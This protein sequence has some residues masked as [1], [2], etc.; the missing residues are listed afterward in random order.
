MFGQIPSNGSSDKLQIGSYADTY[1][2]GIHTK[3]VPPPPSLY[4]ETQESFQIICQRTQFLHI[5]WQGKTSLPQNSNKYMLQN[6][7]RLLHLN[8]WNLTHQVLTK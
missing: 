2:D 4:K 5:L 7:S 3:H 1:T 6:I 8:L